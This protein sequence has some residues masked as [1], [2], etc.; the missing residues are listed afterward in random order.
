MIMTE[1]GKE[2]EREREREMREEREEGGRE[3]GL[4]WLGTTPSSG[5][6]WWKR[7]L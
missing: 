7:V 6:Q 3:I 2:L 5:V 4:I 1:K